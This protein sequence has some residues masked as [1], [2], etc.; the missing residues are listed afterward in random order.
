MRVFKKNKRLLCIF[1]IQKKKHVDNFVYTTTGSVSIILFETT[2]LQNNNTNETFFIF[3]YST[4]NGL[5]LKLQ[6]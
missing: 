5:S 6:F 4:C 1:S 2:E 3:Y